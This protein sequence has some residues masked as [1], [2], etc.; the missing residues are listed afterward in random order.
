MERERTQAEKYVMMAIFE[1]HHDI[2]LITKREHIMGKQTSTFS[3]IGMAIG[4][5][6][7]L[8]A[9]V[10]IWAGPFNRQ[11]TFEDNVKREAM[12]LKDAVISAFKGE[13]ETTTT[14]PATTDIDRLLHILTAV[15]GGI[16]IILAVFA[17]ARNEP[18]R[19]TAAA[20]VLGSAAMAFQYILL[21]VGVLI[22]GIVVV[23]ILSQA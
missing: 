11:P 12:A 22:L 19:A 7:L 4:A 23:T 3:Y 15:L 10:H 20:A 21:A 9:I 13:Q 5:G 18:L 1:K 6:A 16:A 8:L 14:A 17:F 2:P